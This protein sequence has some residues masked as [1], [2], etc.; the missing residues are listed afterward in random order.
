MYAVAGR[1]P[2]RRIDPGFR[3]LFWVVTGQQ[4]STAA[5]RAIF[6]RAETALGELTPEAVNAADDALL[7]TAGL[8]APKIRTLRALSEAILSGGLDIEGLSALDGR[9]AGA[10]LC[11]IKGIGRWTADVYLLFA[12]GHADIFPSGDLALKEGVRLALSLETRPGE[13]E[14]DTL[15]ESWRPFRSAAA[16]LTWAY[17]GAIKRGKADSTPA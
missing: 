16:R 3:G 17:Y 2:I 6:T 15:A 12:L 5:G 11:T 9:E 7:K 4:I 10:Q 14:L 1:V 8:S 13:K